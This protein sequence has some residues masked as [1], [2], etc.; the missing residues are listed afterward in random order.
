MSTISPKRLRKIKEQLNNGK[1]IMANGSEVW[2]RP[3]WTMNWWWI[4]SWMAVFSSVLLAYL[5][6][7]RYFS[8]K[9]PAF[10][11]SEKLQPCRS[12]HHIGKFYCINNSFDCCIVLL[13]F[14]TLWWIKLYI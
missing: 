8:G 5:L 7:Q 1:V 3:G 11:F 13:L 2:T 14:A 4:D 9:F 6:Y 10:C 12:L